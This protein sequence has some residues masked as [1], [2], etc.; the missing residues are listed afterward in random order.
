MVWLNL[1]YHIRQVIWNMKSDCKSILMSHVIWYMNSDC[2]CFLIR[3]VIWCV[4]SDYWILSHQTGDLVYEL[5]L[6]PFSSGMW[7]VWLLNPFPSDLWSGI[8]ALIE[9]FL[10]RHVIWYVMSDYW[11]LYHQACDLVCNVW[12]LNPFSSDMWS[13]IKC[14]C[15]RPW[16]TSYTKMPSLQPFDLICNDFCDSSPTNHVTWLIWYITFSVW[17]VK[18]WHVENG[19]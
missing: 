12:L 4:L 7:S 9:S 2:E 15:D 1:V 16:Q 11:I 17:H 14:D 6:N 18:A 10:I 19:N 5:W 8:W 3:H 13:G